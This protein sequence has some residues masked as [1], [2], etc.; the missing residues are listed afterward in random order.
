[1]S[2]LSLLLK[3][4]FVWSFNDAKYIIKAGYFYVNGNVVRNPKEVVPEGSRLQLPVSKLTY[5]WLNNKKKSLYKGYKKANRLRWYKKRVK[6]SRFR[7]KSYRYPKWL[8]KY[9]MV[10]SKLPNLLE[11]D[12]TILTAIILYRPVRFNELNSPL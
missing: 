12:Y 4:S 7:K 2:A 10:G 3:T 11:V 8:F 6:H 9:A 1:M 5:A